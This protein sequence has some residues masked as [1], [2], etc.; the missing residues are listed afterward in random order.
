VA[1][2]IE[3]VKAIRIGNTNYINPRAAAKRWVEDAGCRRWIL[4]SERGDRDRSTRT[5]KW[6]RDHYWITGKNQRHWRRVEKIMERL[7]K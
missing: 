3:I 4:I 7:L 6:W 2:G 5:W 1:K